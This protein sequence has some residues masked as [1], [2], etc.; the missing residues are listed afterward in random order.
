MCTVF[1]LLSNILAQA[2]DGVE[3]FNKASVSVPQF[4]TFFKQ[5]IIIIGPG[6]IF[7]HAEIAEICHWYHSV[8]HFYQTKA[9][10][11]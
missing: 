2:L 4:A 3:C 5:A 11:V 1:Q 9:V 6:N 7:R 8:D 10:N